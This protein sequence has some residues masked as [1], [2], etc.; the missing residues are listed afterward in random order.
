MKI[1]KFNEFNESISGWE[2]VGQHVMGPNYPEQN[3]PNSLSKFDTQV[4]MGIDGKF[5]TYDDY[6]EL[7]NNHLK[8]GGDNLPD[9]NKENLDFLIKN[10]LY[11]R[12]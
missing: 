7:L 10:T 8:N 11:Y 3:L 9:F 5:Y 6:Q 1:K 2:L 12:V 4:I